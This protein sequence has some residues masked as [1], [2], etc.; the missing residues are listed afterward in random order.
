MKASLGIITHVCFVVESSAL[1]S[2]D[3]QQVTLVADSCVKCGELWESH[4]RVVHVL[5]YIGILRS[6]QH[7]RDFLKTNLKK[8]ERY[9]YNKPTC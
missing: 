7:C 6:R 4:N 5:H 9:A 1:K 8:E 2:I 3:K